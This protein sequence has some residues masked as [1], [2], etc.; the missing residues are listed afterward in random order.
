MELAWWWREYYE[1]YRTRQDGI[2]AC[3]ARLHLRNDL[4]HADAARLLDQQGRVRRRLARQTQALS[5]LRAVLEEEW[6]RD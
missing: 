2:E 3:L 6:R 1:S 4:M 5:Q